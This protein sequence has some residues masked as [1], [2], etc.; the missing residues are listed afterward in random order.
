MPTPRLVITFDDTEALRRELDDNFVN[1]GTFAAGAAGI[2]QGQECEVVIVHPGDGAERVIP[3]R[4]VWLCDAGV[5]VAFADFDEQMLEAL[6][7]FVDFHDVAP[8]EAEPED[9]GED[10]PED[11]GED[12][13]EDDDEI[14]RREPLARNV[15]ERLRNLSGAEQLKVARAGNPT[16]RMVLERLYGRTVWEPLLKNPRITL[17]E[18]IRIAGM[19]SLPRPQLELIAGNQGWLTAPQI[20]RALLR[21]PKISRELILKVLRVTPRHELRTVPKQTAYPSLVRDLAR[22]LL[23]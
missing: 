15:Q 9:D 20:R 12:D 6:R 10:D 17:P 19:R 3:A 18:V 21:H 13:P 14:F 5:G 23:R 1:G 11:D 7:V 8:A 16:E 2:G 22:Q 4:A